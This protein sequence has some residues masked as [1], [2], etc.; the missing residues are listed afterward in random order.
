M[1]QPRGRVAYRMLKRQFQLDDEA[2]EDLKTEL[3]KAQRL[4]VDEDGEVL[5]WSGGSSMASAPALASR[6]TPLAYT[7]Q[8]LVE[9]ILTSIRVLEGE[10][11]QVTVLFADIKDSTELIR[12]L[13]PEAA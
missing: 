2:V 3:V 12:D 7:P 10:R 5:V 1:L 11:K 6:P 13:D 8:H 4:A 9:K